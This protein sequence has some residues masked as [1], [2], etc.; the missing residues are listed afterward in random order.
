VTDPGG[1]RRHSSRYLF[2]SKWFRLRQDGVALP[3]GDR[4]TYTMIEHPGFALVVPMIDERH[5][6]LERLYRYTL[7]AYSLECPAG[8]LDGDAPAAAAI[9]ELREET[10]Y[11]AGSV[12]PLATFNGSTGISDEVFHI[13]LAT[14]L[15]PTGEVQR[16]ATEQMELVQMPLGDAVRLAES[17]GI[18]DSSSALALILAE[19]HLR[20]C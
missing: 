13:F 15:Q 20:S 16:E 7:Q 1:W 19:R 2:E 18:R 14:E 17:G 5:V 6:L 3:N 9:R 4:I 11:V 8:G 12:T 10:G